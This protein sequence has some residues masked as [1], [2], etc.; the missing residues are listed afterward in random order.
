MF[1]AQ[2]QTAVAPLNNDEL[3]AMTYR[4]GNLH[5]AEQCASTGMAYVICEIT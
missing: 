1:P 4:D 5:R 2:V 3:T